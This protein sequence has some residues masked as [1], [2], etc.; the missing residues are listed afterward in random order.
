MQKCLQTENQSVYEHGLSVKNYTFQIIQILKTEDNNSNNLKLPDWIFQ[1]QKEILQS[2]YPEKIIEEYTTFHDLG[3]PY[4]LIIDE[5]GK[6][7]FPNHSEVSYQTWLAIGGNKSV[8]NLIRMDMKIHQIK[9][10][11]IDEFIK[12]PEAITLLIVGLA[13][14]ISNAQLFGGFESDSFKIKYK[15]INKRGKAI[16]EKLFNGEL[17]VIDSNRR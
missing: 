8:A 7:H 9:A 2:L 14:V 5:F 11:E 3:K 13:E 10:I 17:N 16:C 6:R 4:C 15:Q 1:Y 12:Y